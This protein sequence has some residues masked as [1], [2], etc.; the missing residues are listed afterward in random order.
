MKS[1]VNKLENSKVELLVEV[2]GDLWKDAQAS[3]FK[4]AAKDLEV[5]G[6]RK[7]QIP[8]AIAKKHIKDETVMMSAVEEVAQA[9]LIAGIEDN[10]LEL[11]TNPELE[12]EAISD[13]QVKLK[14]ICTVS[15]DVTLGKYKDLGV[16]KPEIAVT[17]TEIAEELE[18]MR[19]QHAELSLKEGKLAEGDTAVLD[20]DGYK[21]DVAFEGG[22]AE[23]FSLEIG[24]GQ[25]I[26]GFEEKM[27]GMEAGEE[28]DVE[29]T[30]PEDYHVEDLKG[31]DVV[32]KVK[33]HEVKERIVPVIDEDFALDVDIEGV[34]TLDDLKENVRATIVE[35]KEEEAAREHEN[36]ILTQVV[37]AATV[38]IPEVMIEQETE[39]LHQD[40]KMRIEQQGIPFDQFIAMTGQDEDALKENLK[41]DAEK[42]VKLR[43]VLF[44]ISEVEKL[45]VTDVDVAKEYE[46]LSKAYNMELEEVKAA[47]DAPNVI[48]DLR[49]RQAYDLVKD[50]N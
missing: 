44:K 39:R 47:I 18:Q 25:F 31:A 46:E 4:K 33:L 42:Q 8:E 10:D 13:T 6:F 1:T 20:F 36:E 23:N 35:R 50:S 9:A 7:G 34:K 15:P 32:F 40:M 17:D 24:S 43:L 26:P 30:F 38:D 22:K 29:L 27:I 41:L 21:D 28:R 19:E 16:E 49:I 2:D 5:K 14:F 45:S 12:V 48:Y 3:A 37:E 11:V